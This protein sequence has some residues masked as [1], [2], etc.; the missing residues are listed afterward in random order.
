MLLRVEVKVFSAHMVNILSNQETDIRT[1][2]HGHYSTVFI[3]NFEQ[4]FA[5]SARCIQLEEFLKIGIFKEGD[6]LN[7]VE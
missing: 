6:S 5:S 3:A 7:Y 2:V 4:I 1:F